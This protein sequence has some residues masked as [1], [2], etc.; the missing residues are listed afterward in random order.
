MLARWSPNPDTNCAERAGRA[1]D[2]AAPASIRTVMNICD[3]RST[4]RRIDN[5]EPNK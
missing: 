4:G 5:Q 1:A 2:L 3:L